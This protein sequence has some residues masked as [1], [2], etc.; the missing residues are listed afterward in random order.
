MDSLAG[1][2]GTTTSTVTPTEKKKGHVQT[3]LRAFFTTDS[4]KS[5]TS[6]SPKQTDENSR[7]G[8]SNGSPDSLA[9][10]GKRKEA[11]SAAQS[12]QEDSKPTSTEKKAKITES[13]D[14]EMMGVSTK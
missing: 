14:Q 12:G 8:N 7:N 4:S 1:L 6:T 3:G 9:S 13:Q 10:V 5:K 11:P 2:N